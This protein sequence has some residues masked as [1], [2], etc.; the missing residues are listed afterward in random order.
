M[1]DFD[2]LNL[3]NLYKGNISKT[4][5]APDMLSEEALIYEQ[6]VYSK[7]R[8]HNLVSEQ[9][10]CLECGNFLTEQEIRSILTEEFDDV[11]DDDDGEMPKCNMNGYVLYEGTKYVCIATGIK[12]PSQN[13][14]TGPM[15]QI[16]MIVKDVHPVEAMKT[17]ENVHV[18][19]SCKHRPATDEER[20]K[21]IKGGA[22]YVDV[23]KSVAQVYK[24]YRKGRYQNICGEKIPEP[25][26]VDSY[27]KLGSATIEEI[28]SGR[29]VRFGAYGEPVLIPH[30]MVKKIISVA[31]GHT[32]YTHTWMNPAF[33]AYKQFFMAS[34]DTDQEY[35][36]A[37]RKGWRTFRVSTSWDMKPNEMICLNSW[38]NKTC[39]ECLQCN[40]A[41]GNRRDIIIKVHGKSKSNFKG[42]ELQ[43]RDGASVAITK[44][45]EEDD[46]TDVY[47]PE[48]DSNPEKTKQ[49]Q[50]LSSSQ[51]VQIQKAEDIERK[52]SEEKQQRKL[53]KKAL[54][55]RE[56]LM[57]G[58]KIGQYNVPPTDKKLKAK[59]KSITKRIKTN[60]D[61][62]EQ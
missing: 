23:A 37:K 19:F 46:I 58:Q 52:E 3:S 56:K 28:F 26:D 6:Y 10:C 54:A 50:E 45:G 40:G 15:I 49:Q 25:N 29:N 7:R 20:A 31:S 61:L 18:C 53:D 21:G 38:Q 16:F 1:K 33:D 9:K 41:G 51:K 24:T 36:I 13:V 57:G 34:A 60:P 35:E 48:D 39:F 59:S 42:G 2:T 43:S 32:G 14:K 11:Q 27:L 62:D 22:C 8:H 44:F 47:N 4:K 12:Q 30:P 5:L 55:Q 17:G